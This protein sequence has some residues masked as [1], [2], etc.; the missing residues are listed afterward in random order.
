MALASAFEKVFE[1]KEG[2]D[3]IFLIHNQELPAHQFILANRS[4]VLKAMIKGP[5]APPTHKG[6]FTYVPAFF[7]PKW[8]YRV[9]NMPK[10]LMPKYKLRMARGT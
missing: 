3:C 1:S 9:Q 6:T 4:P 2:A 5:M 7:T 10:T 8:V